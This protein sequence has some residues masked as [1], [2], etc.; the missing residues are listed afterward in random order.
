MTLLECAE[1]TRTVPF[2][3]FVM[4]ALVLGFW[5]SRR[6]RLTLAQTLRVFAGR[7]QSGVAL[8]AKAIIAA[9]LGVIA[10][11]LIWATLILACKG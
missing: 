5:I 3:L 6:Y 7:P 10:F 9:V 1:Q 2:A 4:G 8:P 11:G